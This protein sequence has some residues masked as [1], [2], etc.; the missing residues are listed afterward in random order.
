MR[1]RSSLVMVALMILV[2]IIV[3]SIIALKMLQ[4]AEL[5]AALRGLHESVNGLALL[6]D[7]ELA[8]T[9]AALQA[10]ASSPSLVNGDLQAFHGQ[11]KS[12]NRGPD[13]WTVLSDPESRQIV[14]TLRPFGSSLP[15]PGEKDLARTIINANKTWASHIRPGPVS[16]KMV[17]TLT[18]PVTLSSGKQYLLSEVFAADHFKRLISTFRV[19]E[20]WYVAV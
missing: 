8:S 18:V 4:H 20:G 9:E 13:A 12:I 11:A 3:S 6:V 19:P 14:N 2:P 17:T 5:K 7:G 1:I 16:G 10:L 15:P